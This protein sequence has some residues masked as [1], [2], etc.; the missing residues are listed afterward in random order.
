MPKDDL[1]G[2]VS[3]LFGWNIREFATVNQNVQFLNS[4][5]SVFPRFEFLDGLNALIDIL[6]PGDDLA[7]HFLYIVNVIGLVVYFSQRLNIILPLLDEQSVSALCIL[8]E[9]INSLVDLFLQ[10]LADAFD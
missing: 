5:G 2:S 3:H 4:K 10:L 8:F 7:N 9:F 6:F 1:E